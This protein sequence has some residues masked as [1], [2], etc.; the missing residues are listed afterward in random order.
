MDRTSPGNNLRAYGT[1]L[2]AREYASNK[3]N[4]VTTCRHSNHRKQCSLLR[5]RV[6]RNVL[7]PHHTAENCRVDV[8]KSSDSAK[9]NHELLPIMVKA[10]IPQRTYW[11]L[12][13]W[14]P[15]TTVPKKRVT[16]SVQIAQCGVSNITANFLVS[17][18]HEEI[19][20]VD[21]SPQD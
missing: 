5:N 1:T 14:L 17:D 19:G 21:K 9:K 7:H 18:G 8:T 4:M 10:V 3:A 12:M 2:T 6:L 20:T 15:T 16:H 13:G 11:M